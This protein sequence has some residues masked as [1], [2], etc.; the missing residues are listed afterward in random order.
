M[1]IKIK[2]M[3]EFFKPKWSKS[4]LTLFLVLYPII[5]IVIGSLIP[6]RESLLS[7]LYILYS[8]VVFLSQFEMP[9]IIAG[10]ILSIIWIYLISCSTI[11]LIKFTIKLIKKIIWTKLKFAVVGVIIVLILAIPLYAKLGL[12]DLFVPTAD[13]TGAT[14]QGVEQLVKANNEFAIE[15]YKELQS[16]TKNLFFSPFSIATAFA[17]VY[18]G[19]KGETASQIE[20]V[21]HFPTDDLTRRASY[22]RMLNTVNKGGGEYK[23]ETANGLWLQED[24]QFLNEYKEIVNTRYIGE[25]KNLDFKNEPVKASREINKW[26]AKNTN[27]KIPT[28]V[29]PENFNKYTRA[30]LTNA[31]YFKGEW[32]EQF[33]KDDTKDEDFFITPTQSTRV[34]MMGL[35]EESF[36]Y[37]ERDGVQIIE[38][39]YKGDKISMLIMLPRLE[40]GESRFN[41]YGETTNMTQLE[42]MLN[43][44]KLREWREELRIQELNVFLPKF[45]FETSYKL[46]DIFKEMGMVLPFE[47]RKADFSGIDG[48]ELL[49]IDEVLHKAF[50][51]VNEEGT[52]AAAVTAIVMN[53]PTSARITHTFRAD[54]PFVFIIQEQNSGNILFMGKVNNPQE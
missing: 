35:F 14:A 36:N 48:T 30:V 51:D 17:M 49:Y 9:G 34:P 41:S 28:I 40:G 3:K 7:I 37:V 22:A 26:A 46:A 31:I 23:L 8:P 16:D 47:E 10:L 18:E 53:V 29:Q 52:E 43:E 39:P 54:H 19:A 13:D 20:S 11:G 32:I 1:A 45:T 4:L 2:L 25:I 42:A 12:A 15:L 21:F 6:I 27:N 50:V 33:D 5:I 38:L 44:S 24:Y